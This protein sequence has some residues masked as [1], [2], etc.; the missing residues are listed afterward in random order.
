MGYPRP[1][2]RWLA[3]KLKMIRT[4]M[5]LSQQEMLRRLG[6]EEAMHYSRISEYEQGSREPSLPTLLKYA[7]VAGVLMEDI[8]DDDLDLPQRLPGSVN[9][10]GTKRKAGSRN[11][12]APKK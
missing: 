11:R 3:Q 10:L 5:G 9:Y 12:S 8:V 2:P 6:L 4:A 7:R 1:K